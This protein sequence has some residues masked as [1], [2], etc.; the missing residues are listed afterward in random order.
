MYVCMC[1][2]MRKRLRKCICEHECASKYLFVCLFVCL[3]MCVTFVF[4]SVND[5]TD[6]RAIV[7]MGKSRKGSSN[8]YGGDCCGAWQAALS[9]NMRQ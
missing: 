2:F 1:V 3:L 6:T 8:S 5:H 4:M 9:A 7:C